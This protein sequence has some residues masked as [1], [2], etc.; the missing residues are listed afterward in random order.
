MM[1]VT[2]PPS[3]TA[4][5]GSSS[6]A[7]TELYRNVM[8]RRAVSLVAADGEFWSGHLADPYC[9]NSWALYYDLAA[10]HLRI[11]SQCIRLVDTPSTPPNPVRIMAHMEEGA[12][13]A[14]EVVLTSLSQEIWRGAMREIEADAGLLTC[15]SMCYLRAFASRHFRVLT[16]NFH[17]ME[18]EHDISGPISV[19]ACA[20][21]RPLRLIS[22][23]FR[24]WR[25]LALPP[26]DWSSYFFHSDEESVGEH[27]VGIHR[28]FT[29][30]SDSSR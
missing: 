23:I 4:E 2:P 24:E 20:D 16:H 5:A 17:L 6:N 25:D 9:R 28:A 18:N 26:P 11:S 8:I 1:L 15:R 10:D 14:R 13:P 3:L 29:D 12:T 19:T 7:L 21:L 27:E 22:V 30:S